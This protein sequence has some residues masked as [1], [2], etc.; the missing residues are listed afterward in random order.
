MR[1]ALLLGLL[2]ACSAGDDTI[3]GTRGQC[4]E[5]GALE[6]CP[7]AEQTPEGACWRLVVC[8]A[9]RLDSMN[10]LNW[11]KCVDGIDGLTSD[12]QRL[13][14]SCVA[15]STCDE[16]RSQDCLQLGGN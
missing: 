14:I 16:L 15:A 10:G 3:A 9:I 11:G 6:D 5:G 1:V 13:V 4:A 7:P 8:G 12:Y 2:A